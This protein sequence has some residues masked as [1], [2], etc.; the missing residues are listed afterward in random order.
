MKQDSQN[1]TEKILA[2]ELEKGTPLDN[3]EAKLKL[4]VF[5]PLHP[6]WL[7]D[8]FNHFTSEAGRKIVANGWKAA[9]I[10]NAISKGV[11]GLPMLDPFHSID[12]LV[13]ISDE[14][15]E[16]RLPNANSEEIFSREND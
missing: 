10:T 6:G 13:E 9:G 2:K 3:I 15:N 14:S 7:I 11:K 12:P 1:G 8:A 5:K 4:S 16:I